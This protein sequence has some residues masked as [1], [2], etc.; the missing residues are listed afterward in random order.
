MTQKNASFRTKNLEQS[1]EQDVNSSDPNRFVG[2][3]SRTKDDLKY[4]SYLSLKNQKHRMQTLE[5]RKES[6]EHRIKRKDNLNLSVLCDSVV[7]KEHRAKNKES[8]GKIII[9][10]ITASLRLKRKK[11]REKRAK[12]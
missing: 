1:K 11:N 9:S 4:N 12:R 7:R 8:G 2:I 6:K 5:Q 10:A 3:V